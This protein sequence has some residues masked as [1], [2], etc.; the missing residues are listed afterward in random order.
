MSWSVPSTLVSRNRTFIALCIQYVNAVS[1]LISVLHKTASIFEQIIIVIV[2]KHG[3]IDLQFKCLL[4]FSGEELGLIES[5]EIREN[6]ATNSSCNDW[7][8]ASI[9][10]GFKAME[11][12]RKSTETEALRS[13]QDPTSDD[14]APNNSVGFALGLVKSNSVVA[15]A[16]MWQQLQQQAKG[17]I[18]FIMNVI[19]V[20]TFFRHYGTHTKVH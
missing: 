1:N 20:D 3:L 11:R 17:I 7:S 15:R 2:L 16:S 10:R 4:C 9:E 8:S 14:E 18:T 12:E 6:H 13:P 5:Q 19:H